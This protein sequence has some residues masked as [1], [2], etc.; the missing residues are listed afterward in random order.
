LSVRRT[1]AK[2]TRR[3][4]AIVKEPTVDTMF[5]KSQPVPFGKV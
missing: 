2:K 1:L 4:R 3:P 5:Q